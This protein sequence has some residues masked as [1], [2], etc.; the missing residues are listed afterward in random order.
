[1]ATVPKGPGQTEVTGDLR[2]PR[3]PE[4]LGLWRDPE[5]G[6]ELEVTMGAGADA[7]ARLGWKHIRDLDAGETAKAEE[8]TGFT[9]EQVDQMIAD[10][11]AKQGSTASDLPT[12]SQQAT[13]NKDTSNS[14]PT[15]VAEPAANDL[16]DTNL[17][18]EKPETPSPVDD[19]D[20]VETEQDNA[21]G[22]KS[23]TIDGAPGVPAGDPEDLA[24]ETAKK[25]GK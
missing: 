3:A 4:P 15:S 1:M 14:A 18:V 22:H 9:Q 17:P 25:S 2:D 8:S 7:L 23:E 11:L 12:Q 21:Q 6:A 16:N 19:A 24:D 10:A 20:A 5:S 13:D